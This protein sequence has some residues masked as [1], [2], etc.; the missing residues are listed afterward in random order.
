LLLAQNHRADSLKGALTHALNDTDKINILNRLAHEL[1]NNNPDSSILLSKQALALA[2]QISWIKGEVNAEY[3]L[4][5]FYDTK[6]NIST[7]IEYEDSAL[8]L[9]K[10]SDNKLRFG[11]VYNALGNLASEQNKFA[12]GLDYYFK[13]LDYDSIYDKGFLP[14]LYNNIG[15]DYEDKGDYIKAER[16]LFRSLKN[17]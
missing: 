14:D 8:V 4:G 6:G 16:Y 17:V 5:T 9:C 15:L 3:Q 7:G 10:K 2:R 11:S 1:E 12:I 13:A